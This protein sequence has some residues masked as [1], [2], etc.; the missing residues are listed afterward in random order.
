MSHTLPE[1]VE[2][3]ADGDG[4]VDGDDVEAV[5]RYVAGYDEQI[6]EEAADVDD[7]GDVDIVDAAA[8]DDMRGD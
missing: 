6:D 4:D 8:I 7:D 1:T 3:D 2:G 5:Q